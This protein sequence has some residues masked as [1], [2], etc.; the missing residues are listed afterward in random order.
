MAADAPTLTNGSALPTQLHSTTVE[1]IVSA[2]QAIYDPRSSNETRQQA[3]QFLDDQKADISAVEHGFALASDHGQLSVVRHFGCSLMEHTIRHRWQDIPDAQRLTI[4]KHVL[5]LAYNITEQDA[6]YIRGK[7]GNIWVELAKKSWG[8]E[9]L[10]MD[11]LLLDL[12]TKGSIYI[13]LVLAI[14]EALSE[15][16]FSR[17]DTAAALRGTEL[18]SALVEVFSPASQSSEEDGK[19]RQSSNLRADAKGWLSRIS[20]LLASPAGSHIHDSRIKYRMTSALETL[21]TVLSWVMLSAVISTGCFQSICGLL[22][23]QDDPGL[24]LVGAFSGRGCKTLIQ[25]VGCC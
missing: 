12:W 13:D 23:S 2:L 10:D 9:W 16:V 21:R 6:P 3:T 7:I 8:V 20:E 15:D 18:S 1:A 11:A 22:A 4:R 17:D 24:L 14:L 25:C 5:E 19:T